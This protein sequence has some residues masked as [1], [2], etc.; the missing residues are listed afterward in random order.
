MTILEKIEAVKAV[1]KYRED[2]C[3]KL[4]DV[5]QNTYNRFCTKVFD[6]DVRDRN[7]IAYYDCECRGFCSSDYQSI[8]LTWLAEGFDYQAAYEEQERQIFR[9]A[10]KRAGKMARENLRRKRKGK[11]K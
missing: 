2:V 6:F 9:N 3:E 10:L 1:Q 5:I 8:P 11:S 4:T 7:L